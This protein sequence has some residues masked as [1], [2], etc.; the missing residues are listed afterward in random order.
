M[1]VDFWRGG[2]RVN[3]HECR[4]ECGEAEAVVVNVG[5]HVLYLCRSDWARLTGL[6]TGLAT[7]VRENGSR[8]LDFTVPDIGARSDS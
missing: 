3:C 2:P 5:N 7:V 6:L 4:R 1:R 8:A